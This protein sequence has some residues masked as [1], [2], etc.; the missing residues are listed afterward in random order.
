MMGKMDKKVEVDNER[1][2]WTNTQRFKIDFDPIQKTDEEKRLEQTRRRMR[3]FT[4]C[5]R[6]K[7]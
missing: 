7:L 5:A 2:S 1:S 4:I 3:G 6:P